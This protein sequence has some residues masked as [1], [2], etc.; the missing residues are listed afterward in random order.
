MKK[1]FT[2]TLL[3]I[4]LCIYSQGSIFV[5]NFSPYQLEFSLNA[6]NSN[7]TTGGCSPNITNW[8]NAFLLPPGGDVNF[9]S[10][11]NAYTYPAIFNSA[12]WYNG[13]TGTLYPSAGAPYPVLNLYSNLTTW[14]F[15]KFGV[16]DPVSGAN[17]PNGNFSQIGTVGCGTSTT[18][19]PTVGGTGFPIVAEWYTI[20]GETYFIIQ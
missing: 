1:I 15:S 20:N 2:L 17:I 16:K 11:N 5:Y 7:N 3:F 10:F 4:S 9:T 6:N 18:Y 12:S 8:N 13:N 19:I 14:K